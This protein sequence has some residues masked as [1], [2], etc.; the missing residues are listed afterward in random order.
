MLKKGTQIAA[1]VMANGQNGAGSA[2]MFVMPNIE[3]TKVSGCDYV[4][5]MP[6]YVYV[7]H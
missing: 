7:N 4:S 6:W 5:Q 3:V 1:S 2:G